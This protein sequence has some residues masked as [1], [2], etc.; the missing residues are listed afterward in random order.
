[1]I[2]ARRAVVVVA[3]V[4]PMVTAD[5]RVVVNGAGTVVAAGVAVARA[6]MIVEAVVVAM[7]GFSVRCEAE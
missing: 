5:R 7:P 3:V 4:R 1:M 6:A 2:I